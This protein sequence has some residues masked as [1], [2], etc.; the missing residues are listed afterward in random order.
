[1]KPEVSMLGSMKFDDLHFKRAYNLCIGRGGSHEQCKNIP[2]D[3]HIT[4]Q[5]PMPTVFKAETFNAIECMTEHG[6]QEKCYHYTEYLHKKATFTDPPKTTKEKV[7]E[8][9]TITNLAM[10]PAALAFF[11][12]VQIS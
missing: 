12:F 10:I 9:A 7:W 6:D 1:M 8:K 5:N 2:M 3:S 11:K 4:P